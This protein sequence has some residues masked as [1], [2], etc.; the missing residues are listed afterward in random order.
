[1][2]FAFISLFRSSNI[3]SSVPGILRNQLNDQ[4]PVGL[5]LFKLSFVLNCDD[6]LCIQDLNVK[7]ENAALLSGETQQKGAVLPCTPITQRGTTRD[8]KKLLQLICLCCYLHLI[9]VFIMYFFMSRKALFKQGPPHYHARNLF[10]THSCSW[11]IYYLRTFICPK[12]FEAYFNMVLM[13]S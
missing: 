13:K 11:R 7:E 9:F 2:I 5:K 8:M 4:L 6:L 1:M 3:S 10:N 12:Q